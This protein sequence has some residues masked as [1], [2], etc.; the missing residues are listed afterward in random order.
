MAR[1]RTSLPARTQV[2]S[3]AGRLLLPALHLGAC[4][5][6]M[7]TDGGWRLLVVTVDGALRLW[8]L[9]K[10]AVEVEASILPLLSGPAGCVEGARACC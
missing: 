4:A 8:D 6:F 2:V 10:Q 1:P 5:A 9:Q 7:A 3:P